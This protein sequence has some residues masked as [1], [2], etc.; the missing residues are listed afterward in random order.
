MKTILVESSNGYMAKGPNDTMTW[1]PVLDKQIFKLLTTIGGVCVCS[2]HTY[3]LLPQKMLNDPA[4]EFIV[5]EKTGAKSL[6]ALNIVHPGAYL[7]GGPVFLKAAY[8]M[9]VI[10]TIIIATTKEPIESN[11]RYKNPFYGNLREPVT[12]INF[13][14]LIVRIYKTQH[15]R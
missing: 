5:A 3:N 13:D 15:G 14:E 7:I 6:P 4:R 12:K 8:N 9:S 11:E 1:T 2:K 10:D